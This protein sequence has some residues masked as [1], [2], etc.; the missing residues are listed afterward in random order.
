[1]RTASRQAPPPPTETQAKAPASAV[2]E[3]ETEVRSPQF[4]A[5]AVQMV[6]STSEPITEVARDPGS[7]MDLGELGERLAAGTP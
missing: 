7:T 6:I 4:K 3:R 2:T 5:E 1:M